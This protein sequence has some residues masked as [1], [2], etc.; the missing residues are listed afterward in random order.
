MKIV[1]DSS[2]NLLTLSQ[3]PFANAPLKMITSTQEFIDDASLDV[4]QMVSFFETYKEKSK[5]SCPNTGDFLTAFGDADDIFCVTITS[6]LSGCYNAACMA[7]QMYETNNPGKRVRVIDTLSTGPE[8]ELLIEKLT[9]WIKSGLSYEQILPLIEPYQEQTGLVFMLASL[10][11]FAANGR[12]SPAVAKIAGM[13]GIRIVGKASEKGTL[14]PLH[15]CRGEQ[16]SVEA[17]YSHLKENGLKQGKVRIAH[18]Q[19]ETLAETLKNILK[20]RLPKVETKIIKCRGL[21]SYYAEKGGL[22]VGFEKF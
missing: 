20:E 5:T 1:A 10:K 6:G 15:K 4:E 8:M 9:E 12:V 21:C 19:N 22:L 2:A 14:E 17:I 18:C 3:I 16:K 7:K 13:L 11:N